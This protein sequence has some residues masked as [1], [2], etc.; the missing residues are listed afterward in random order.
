M[1][2][3]QRIDGR[4][5]G[6]WYEHQLK[7]ERAGDIDE[8]RRARSTTSSFYLTITGTRYTRHVGP[9]AGLFA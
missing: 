2:P 6:L 5:Q 8:G 9:V 1:R 3:Q 4:N 7:A